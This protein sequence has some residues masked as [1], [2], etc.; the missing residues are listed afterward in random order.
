MA[1]AYHKLPPEFL[2]FG[3]GWGDQVTIASG[4]CE[5]APDAAGT[6]TT[7]GGILPTSKFLQLPRQLL[8]LRHG[9]WEFLFLLIE[10]GSDAV[11]VRGYEWK[12]GRGIMRMK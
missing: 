10:Q 6:S 5:A 11:Q 9:Q 3:A 12:N 1:R 4:T 8:D 7:G 2:Q